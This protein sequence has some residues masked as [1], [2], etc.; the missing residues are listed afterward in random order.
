MKVVKAPLQTISKSV[1]FL[2]VKRPKKIMKPWGPGSRSQQLG[3]PQVVKA[4]MAILSCLMST[5]MRINKY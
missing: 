2:S 1:C 4:Y 5:V 3:R